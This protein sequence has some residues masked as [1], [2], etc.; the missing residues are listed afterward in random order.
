V[1]GNEN[2]FFYLSKI[3][4]IDSVKMDLNHNKGIKT[5]SLLFVV[6][7]KPMNKKKTR[8]KLNKVHVKQKNYYKIISNVVYF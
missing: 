2:N 1:L 3:S 5:I 4:S 7:R 8:A 6:K